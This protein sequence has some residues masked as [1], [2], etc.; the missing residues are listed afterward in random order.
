MRK[1][2][3]FEIQQFAEG[4][5][6]AG[7]GAGEGTG[8]GVTA[9]AAAQQQTAQTVPDLG[10]PA[11]KR[12]KWAKSRERRGLSPFQAS[13][14]APA[15]AEPKTEEQTPEAQEAQ[16]DAGPARMSWEDILKDPEYK[17]AFDNQV[18]GIVR[19]R[20]S[21]TTQSDAAMK[22]LAPGLT[23]LMAKYG[24]ED[25]DFEGLTKAITQDPQYY[26]RRAAELGVDV[27][28]AQKLANAEREA[29]AART[30]NRNI[31]EQQQLNQHYERLREQAAGLIQQFPDFDLAKELQNPQF[32]RMT[33]PQ[34]NMSVEDAFFAIHHREIEAAR[35]A[36]REK[37]AVAAV[38][39]TIRAGQSRPRE[40]GSSVA[41]T[42]TTPMYSQMSPEQRAQAKAQMKAAWARGESISYRNVMK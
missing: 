20:L 7:E 32:L 29:E 16:G 41:A 30:A 19:N 12:E 27:A 22:Q 1:F 14:A 39:N 21:K 13:A 6:A 2:K 23:M 11:D 5:A 15:A 18:Q 42:V 37:A 26:E 9:E 33:S 10:I 31:V 3:W 38:A 24:L 17:A 28:T 35:K 8:A 40:N 36:E 4:A 34:V 25:N